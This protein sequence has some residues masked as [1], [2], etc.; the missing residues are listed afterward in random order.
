[1]QATE[2]GDGSDLAVLRRLDGPGGRR[3][4]LQRQVRPDVV[5]VIDVLS[6]D[7][8]EM[9]LIEGDHMVEAFPP[10]RA[11][12]LLCAWILPRRPRRD[13]H[14]LDVHPL[15]ALSEGLAVDRVSLTD[16]VLRRFVVG[17]G[18]ADLPGCPL[19]R[20]VGDGGFRGRTMYLATVDSA[21]VCPSS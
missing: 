8:P 2:V 1:M 12:H 17:E 5:V 20:R 21:T 19:G 14:F 15:D 7:R 9:V 18:L 6:Q 10:D 16:Q 3:I 13:E 4:A 11:D